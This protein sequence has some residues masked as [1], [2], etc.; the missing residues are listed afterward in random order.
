MSIPLFSVFYLSFSKRGEVRM[1]AEAPLVLL[2]VM[3]Q[4]DAIIG[5]KR[6]LFSW[7]WKDSKQLHH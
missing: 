2:L 3:V 4:Y 6:R 1:K 5:Y 7:T